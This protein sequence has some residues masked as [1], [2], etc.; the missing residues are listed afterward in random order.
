M[1]LLDPR[2]RTVVP[3]EWIGPPSLD[4]SNDR[5]CKKSTLGLSETSTSMLPSGKACLIS[6]L[7]LL[8][9]ALDCVIPD[10]PPVALIIQLSDLHVSK[11]N[12]G[13]RLEDLEAFSHQLLSVWKP[14][15]IVI[16]GDLTDAKLPSGRGEQLRSEWRFFPQWFR[17]ALYVD[18]LDPR[19][20]C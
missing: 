20:A 9:C 3:P 2:S 12:Q 7:L 16:T 18:V 5:A 19:V 10:S 11:Y 17:P 6:L 8:S 13:S 14:D 1:N 4:R 15:S